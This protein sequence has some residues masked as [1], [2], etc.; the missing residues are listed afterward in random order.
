[1][2]TKEEAFARYSQVELWFSHYYKFMFTFTGTASDGAKIYIDVGGDSDE[3]YRMSVESN[4]LE[5]V[6]HLYNGC[7]RITISKEG[8][9]L[10]EEYF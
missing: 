8:Q 5:T 10:F 4:L 6:A 1:M 3:I 7:H 2:L 9:I